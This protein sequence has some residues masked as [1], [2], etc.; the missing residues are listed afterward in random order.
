MIF[1][2]QSSTS[3]S[4]KL[5]SLDP[6]PDNGKLASAQ[7]G[8]EPVK[9]LSTA[10]HGRLQRSCYRSEYGI[11]TNKASNRGSRIL[12]KVMGTVSTVLLPL[13][14]L[15]G[16]AT[17]ADL[18]PQASAMQV[19]LRGADAAK[20]A[21]YASKNTLILSAPPRDTA[22][23]GHRIFDPI[24]DYLSQAIGRRVVYKHPGT[25]GGYQADMQA[26]VYD[27]VFDGP[28]FVSWRI[29]K[30][31]HNVLVR[32][33][34]DFIYTA[35]V[36][37]DNMMATELSQLPG[38][39][40]CA[41]APPN[42]GTL[43]MYDQFSNPARQPVVIVQ[44]G[45]RQIYNAVLKGECEVGMLPLY[46]L[47]KFE[48]EKASPQ[49]RIIFQTNAMPQQAFSAG[50]RVTPAEQAKITKALLEPQAPALADFRRVYGSGH[51]LVAATDKD[52]VG[53]AQY[54]RDQW[55]F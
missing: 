23:Q 44:E 30:L 37:K 35:V 5:V 50:P 4:R 40:I 36:R 22:E 3:E 17:A 33:P 24:A 2:K 21:D 55:G 54:L 16:P 6:K 7:L 11:S 51:G 31:G 49:T 39:K 28:H 26:G 42:L 38:H 47:T 29:K 18:Q 9:K 43:I 12:Q 25:W 14:F 27:I 41:H 45:Y 48:K 34:G 19:A 8:L 32:I 10:V 46:E 52:Y 1:T 53:L 13:A 20:P 15:A